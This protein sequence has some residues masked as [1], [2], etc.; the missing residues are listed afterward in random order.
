MM[1]S[2][3]KDVLYAGT[4]DCFKKIYQNE[5]GVKP[6]FKGAASN[7]IRGTGGALVLTI[8]NKVQAYM[9]YGD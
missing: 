6:F 5:G 7:I 1:Q 9:G 8:Y 2:G 3:R 4:M